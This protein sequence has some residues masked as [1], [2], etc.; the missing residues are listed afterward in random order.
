MKAAQKIASNVVDL[1]FIEDIADKLTVL[2]W[3]T[4]TGPTLVWSVSTIQLIACCL[5]PFAM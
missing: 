1:N 4:L 2:G 3:K 5:L